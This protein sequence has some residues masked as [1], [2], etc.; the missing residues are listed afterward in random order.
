MTRL[1]WIIVIFAMVLTHLADFD[2][3]CIIIVSSCHVAIHEPTYSLAHEVGWSLCLFL[4]RGIFPKEVRFSGRLFSE[5]PV[6]YEGHL[7][8][9]R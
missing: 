4:V 9:C 5:L 1:C 7:H 8:R 3:R 6:I 2:V